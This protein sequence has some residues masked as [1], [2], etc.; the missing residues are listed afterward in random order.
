MSATSYEKEDRRLDAVVALLQGEKAGDVGRKFDI[1]RSD[2]YKF[3]RRALHAM[4]EALKDRRRGPHS[5]HNKLNVALEQRV[6][7]LCE[8]YPTLSSYQIHRRIGEDAPS[9]RT[10]QRLRKRRGLPRVPKRAPPTVAARRLPERIVK[11]AC[12]AI[13]EKPHLGPERISWDL[14]NGAN[15]L[16][17]PS[18]IKR[19]KYALNPREPKP[20]W[21]FYERSRPHDLWHGDFME[22]IR[23]TDTWPPQYAL[24][25][26]ILDDYSRGYVFCD[27][28]IT[29]DQRHVIRGMISAMRRWYAI[30]KVII[31]DNG[32]PFKGKL[33]STFCQNLGI[34]LTH[35]AVCHPQT[36]GKLERAFRDDMKDFYK[37]FGEW[38]L[39]QLRRELPDYLNYRNYVRGHRALGGK[40]SITRLDE[41]EDLVDFHLLDKLE[42]F[43][44]YEVGRKIISTGGCIRMFGRSVRVGAEFAGFEVTFFETLEGLEAR[45]GDKRIGLLKNYRDLRQLSPWNWERLPA[46]LHFDRMSGA[47]R[48]MQN[49]AST[50]GDLLNSRRTNHATQMEKWNS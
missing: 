3:R 33:I 16:I 43:A 35:T 48:H 45:L 32:S 25:L 31:F 38:H 34:R 15:M 30:P 23:I 44:S 7:A 13:R 40:P 29:P 41:H 47:D 10:I 42:S 8:R 39:D 49:T 14:Q 21:K 18:S 5:P 20:V 12:Q 6:I 26:A 27:L 36:N 22:K 50:A 9:P 11:R 37:T 24:Q 4:R 17:S 1:A 28:F 19:L 46:T 2:L